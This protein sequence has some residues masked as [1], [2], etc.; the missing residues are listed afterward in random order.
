MATDNFA[1]CCLLD[2]II[3]YWGSDSVDE[4]VLIARG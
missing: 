4:I 3:N 2:E 1:G